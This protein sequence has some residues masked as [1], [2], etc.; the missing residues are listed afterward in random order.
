MFVAKLHAILHQ[1]CLYMCSVLHFKPRDL[2]KVRTCTA[3][4]QCIHAV[5]TCT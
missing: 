4:M 1:R 3:Y 2:Y 5:H